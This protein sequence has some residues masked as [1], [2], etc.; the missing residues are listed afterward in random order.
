MSEDSDEGGGG[1]GWC[2]PAMLFIALIDGIVALLAG[3]FLWR[4]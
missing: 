3:L 1:G 2:L 4:C